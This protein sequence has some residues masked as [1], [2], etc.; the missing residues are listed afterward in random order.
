MPTL[1]DSARLL[2]LV[3]GFECQRVLLLADLVL[4]RYLYGTPKR[5]SREAP[6]LIL[7]QDR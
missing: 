2:E 4:D 6:V 3:D 7:R 1:P 5:I